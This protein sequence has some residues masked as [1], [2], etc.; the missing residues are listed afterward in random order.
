KSAVQSLP[1]TCGR[2]ATADQ[3]KVRCEDQLTDPARMVGDPRELRSMGWAPKPDRVLRIPTSRSECLAIR[4]IGKGEHGG[5]MSRQGID[6]QAQL[7]IPK[8]DVVIISA[9]CQSLP[10]RRE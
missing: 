2:I 10:V 9:R 3:L 6:Q 4:R 5:R 1:E 8:L 7:R